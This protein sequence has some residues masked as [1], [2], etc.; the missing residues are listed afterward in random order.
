[1]SESEFVGGAREAESLCASGKWGP[2]WPGIANE[3]RKK[4]CFGR[5]RPG[6]LV[7]MAAQSTLDVPA[8]ARICAGHSGVRLVVL[9]GSVARG[10]AR[11]DS[12]VDVAV[13]GGEFWDQLGLG[14]EVATLLGR[15]PHLV[16]LSA[17]S[18]WLRF[19]V[20]RDGV[21]AYEAA[22]GL[23]TQFKAQAM[24]LYWDLAPTIALC[25]AGVKRRLLQEARN[26]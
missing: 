25:A 11:A 8:L 3:S 17:A 7:A 18:D 20:V 19:Q 22:P 2:P 23:W 21:L 14:S 13:L 12:D 9:F 4:T 1:M 15:E 16:D 6:M 10:G 5:F 26:G 24:V